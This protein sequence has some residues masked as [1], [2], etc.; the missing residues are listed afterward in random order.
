MK[1]VVVNEKSIKHG[2]VVVDAT[3]QMIGRLASKVASILI[4]K[5]KV[6][7]SPNQDHG[8]YVIVINAE[9][10]KISGKKSV[11][12]T[13]FSHSQHPGHGK[14]RSYRE[15][16]ERDP[17]EVIRH[18]V[19]GMI[20]KGPLGRATYKKLHVYRDDKHPHAAQMPKAVSV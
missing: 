12:K 15:L 1:T 7:Y 16:M 13:Y 8:D 3:N 6:A 19:Y 20:P 18:A 9:K 10:V 17:A 14:F 11:T 2:W 4:G 5:S